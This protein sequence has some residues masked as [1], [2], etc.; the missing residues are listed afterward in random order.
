MTPSLVVCVHLAFLDLDFRQVLGEF[1]TA[2]ISRYYIYQ[3]RYF[4]SL[5]S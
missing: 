5:P 2:F 4:S 1:S 3:Q